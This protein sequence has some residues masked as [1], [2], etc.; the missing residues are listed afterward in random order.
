MPYEELHVIITNSKGCILESS[1]NF[2]NLFKITEAL[3]LKRS[4]FEIATLI[5]D[6]SNLS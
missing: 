6:L 2:A 4:E 5:R 1:K 3:D